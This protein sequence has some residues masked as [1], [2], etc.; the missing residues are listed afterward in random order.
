M[1]IGNQ[2]VQIR[3]R[4]SWL[5]WFDI[6]FLL[7]VHISAHDGSDAVV[8]PRCDAVHRGL[9]FV[10]QSLGFGK[11]L[12]L[13]RLLF[14][15]CPVAWEQMVCLLQDRAMD[16]LLIGLSNGLCNNLLESCQVHLNKWE[17]YCAEAKTSLTFSLFGSY[18]LY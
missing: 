13:Q 16:K 14:C 10:H 15:R 17:V 5:Y 18:Q 8:R 7:S 1:K 11:R 3:C 2:C 9:Y 4:N 6:V 12:I